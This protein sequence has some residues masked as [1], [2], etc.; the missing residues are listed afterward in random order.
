MYKI[1][2]SIKKLQKNKKKYYDKFWKYIKF[3]KIKEKEQNV[4]LK[5]K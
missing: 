2:F 1:F 3:D 5:V 4:N